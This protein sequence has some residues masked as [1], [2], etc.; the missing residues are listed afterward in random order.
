MNLIPEMLAAELKASYE[1]PNWLCVSFKDT[2]SKI[3]AEKAFWKPTG[4]VHAIAE[5]ICHVIAYRQALIKVLTGVKTW[6]LD[7]E[8]SFDT[9]P[10]GNE[11]STCWI[12]IKAILETTQKELVTLVAETD[13]LDKI[14]PARNYNYQTFIVGIISHDIYHLGQIVILAKQYDAFIAP[15]L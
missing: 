13:S 4:G 5:I 2:I 10:Y 1:G 7:Q 12:N 11:E 3:D 15:D 9:S 6:E 14:V 8:H